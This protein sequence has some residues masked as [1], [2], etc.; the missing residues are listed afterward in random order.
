MKKTKFAIGE[1]L[2][3]SASNWLN[4]VLMITYQRLFTVMSRGNLGEEFVGNVIELIYWCL[5]KLFVVE[6]TDILVSQ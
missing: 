2:E 5:L 1:R 3:L 6:V 4:P